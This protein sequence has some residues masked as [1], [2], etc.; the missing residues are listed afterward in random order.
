MEGAQ[1]RH[2][3][4]LRPVAR[5]GMDFAGG[6]PARRITQTNGGTNAVNVVGGTGNVDPQT[7]RGAVVVVKF[8]L[9]PIL[10]DDEIDTAIVVEVGEGGAALFAIDFDAGLLAGNREKIS[11]AITTEP[12]AATGVATVVFAR[13]G[14]EILADKGVFVAIAIEVG[15]LHAESRSHLGF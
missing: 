7:G 3:T 6:P 9:G 13:E 5:A 15:D 4:V 14:E 12:Q 2:G 10:G 11:M 1:D 8:G